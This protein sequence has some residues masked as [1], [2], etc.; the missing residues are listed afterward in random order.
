MHRTAD[1]STEP[2]L[3]QGLS[4]LGADVIA[5][6]FTVPE[7][8]AFLHK[9]TASFRPNPTLAEARIL[10]WRRA[11]GADD[12][13]FATRLAQLGVAEADLPKLLGDLARV[14]VS[15]GGPVPSWWSVCEGV[16]AQRFERDG[17]GLPVLPET[18][19]RDGGTDAIGREPIRFAHAV[20]PWVEFATSELRRQSPGVGRVLGA[21]VLQTE[22]HG[23]T[24]DL[25]RCVRG[26]L[27]ASFEHRRTEIYSTN[28]LLFRLLEDPPPREAY[29]AVVEEALAEGGARFMRRHPALARLLAMRVLFWIGALRELAERLE[30]DRPAIEQ[31]FNG[32]HPLGALVGGGRGISDSHNGGRAVMVCRFEHGVAVYKPRSMSIDAGWCRIVK[33]FNGAVEPE[34]RLRAAKVL[35]RGTHGWMEFVPRRACRDLAELRAFHRRTGATLALVH[36][37]Q[38]N[39]FH[40]ENLVAAGP[41]P[42]AIDLETITVGD[43]VSADPS[44]APEPAV[45]L[46]ARS[47]TRTLLLPQVFA[48]RD[49]R[50]GLR[51]IGALGEGEGAGGSRRLVHAFSD[52]PRWED[53]PVEAPSD[54]DPAAQSRPT[55]AD[56]GEID[57]MAHRGEVVEGY[58]AGYRAILALRTSWAGRIDLGGAIASAWARALNRPTNVYVRLGSETCDSAVASSGVDRWIRAERLRVGSSQWGTLPARTVEIMRALCDAESDAILRGDVPYLV[59]RVGE[60]R[61]HTADPI[62]GLPQRIERADLAKSASETSRRQLDAMGEAD[63]AQQVRLIESSYLSAH[64]S[65]QELLLVRSGQAD[66]TAEA[67]AKRPASDAEIDAFVVEMLDRLESSVIRSGPDQVSWI[68]AV[69]DPTT[70]AIRPTALGTGIYSGRGGIV[71]LL[72]AAYRHFG[73]RELLDLARASVGW[74]AE[75]IRKDPRRVTAMFELEAVSGMGERCGLLAACWALGRH[76]GCGAYR[77]LARRIVASISPRAIGRDRSLDV[78]NGGAGAMLL[79]MSLLREDPSI[80]VRDVVVAIGEHLVANVSQVDGVGW[81][82]SRWSRSLN[83]L[84]HGRAGIA[85]ALVEAGARF[86]RPDFRTLAIEALRAEHA[87]Y[88]TKGA[89]GWPDLRAC[90]PGDP[91]PAPSGFDAWCAGADGIALARAAVLRHIDEPFL[92]EDL[93]LALARIGAGTNFIRRHHLCCGSAGRIETLRVLGRLLGQPELREQA[94]RHALQATAPACPERVESGVS[95][96]QGYPGQAWMHLALSM[97]EPTSV[98][99]LEA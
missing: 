70:G 94:R 52:F 80:E 28:D 73:R 92:R 14:D 27:E 76:E 74:H 48:Q 21:E 32:G 1:R 51:N 88:S 3:D 93:D 64:L 56:G 59:A 89:G 68:D 8:I 81:I 78:I 5:G 36:A 42:V 22:R 75:A 40:S 91:I 24:A 41:Y 12:A 83:G 66:V 30:A 71:R 54:D 85:L 39:D 60:T 90:R 62:S 55:L 10:A 2:P 34:Y 33:A 67:L 35:D 58:R 44:T 37:L 6:A 86:D 25:A 11:I 9:R 79:M 7:R 47:V 72:E 13:A 77:D 4:D 61:Y 45:E 15:V 97:D 96:L 49:G 19:S 43:P 46:V 98:L 18:P 65:M 87:M 95:L 57:P 53:A 63:L 16:L 31:A 82:C 23:L 20:V 26:V 17:D 84:G 38:G 50:G 99:L 29:A 69:P